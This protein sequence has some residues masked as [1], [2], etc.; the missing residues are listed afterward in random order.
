MFNFF[1][2]Q[3]LLQRQTEPCQNITTREV[4]EPALFYSPLKSRPLPLHPPSSANP[5]TSITAFCQGGIPGSAQ[6]QDSNKGG[7]DSVD[8]NSMDR[9]NGGGPSSI[10]ASL[11]M[12]NLSDSVLKAHSWLFSCFYQMEVKEIPQESLFAVKFLT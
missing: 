7:K 10:T 8:T 5:T 12:Q 3:F 2:L 1:H 9:E 11:W 4:S 6:L